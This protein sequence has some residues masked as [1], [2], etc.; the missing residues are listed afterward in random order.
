MITRR[1][2]LRAGTVAGVFT[3][4]PGGAVSAKTGTSSVAFDAICD[5]RIDEGN[6]FLGEINQHAYRVHGIEV[7]P[8]SVMAI[9]E[10]AAA[11]NRPV[12]GLTNDDA[13][14]IAEQIAS[15]H[16]YTLTY[17]GVHS[18]ASADQIEH[19]LLIS[20]VWQSDIELPLQ[21]AENGW[22]QVIAKIIPELITQKRPASE[23]HIT[24]QSN[25]ANSSPG[26]LVS[27]IL[28]PA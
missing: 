28:Q 20:E 3:A 23:Q 8:G 11:E 21:Q 4:I 16:G 7:D 24:A 18:H 1:E 12:V 15:G 9:I 27:W 6:Q 19:T 22:P 25:R 13:L 14:L 10:A 2:F 17:K 26:H 5:T